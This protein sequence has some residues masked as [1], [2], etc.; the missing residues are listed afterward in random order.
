MINLR[1]IS[2]L[3]ALLF[4]ISTSFANAATIFTPTSADVNFFDLSSFL[5]GGPAKYAIFD[6]TNTTLD[7][8]DG[9]L[10]LFVS[11]PFAEMISFTPGTGPDWEIKNLANETFIL[12]GSDSFIL[13]ASW[14]GATWFNDVFV[15]ALVNNSALVSFGIQ[16]VIQ[17]VDVAIVPEP[18]SIILMLGGLMVLLGLRAIKRA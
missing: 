13:A 16:G 4:L 17:A 11:D 10:D 1:K 3:I 12:S 18:S 9:F 5:G 7:I 14:D 15:T 2:A 8:T 6:D